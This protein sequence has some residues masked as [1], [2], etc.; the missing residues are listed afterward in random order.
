MC[1]A[2]DV[3]DNTNFDSNIEVS[4]PAWK[5]VTL[6]LSFGSSSKQRSLHLQKHSR[7]KRQKLSLSE[8][9]FIR[10]LNSFL[11]VSCTHSQTG[12][13]NIMPCSGTPVTWGINLGE[14]NLTVASLMAKS[15]MRAFESDAIKNAGITLD[16]LEIGN[17]PDLYGSNGHRP[18]GY[19]VSD[20]VPECADF[21]TIE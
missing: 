15:V 10:L 16:F 8:T 4:I 2:D 11:L 18:A 21:L 1:L 12:S 6:Q 14:N 13:M 20:Y 17:E 7:I 9:D 5:T 19:S 3:K